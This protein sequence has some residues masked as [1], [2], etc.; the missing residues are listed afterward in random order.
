[1]F[2]GLFQIRVERMKLASLRPAARF[3]AP[4]LVVSAVVIASYNAPVHISGVNAAA[5]TYT[6]PTPT[7]TA[8]A[9][10]SGSTAGMYNV[11]I[12]GTQFCNGTVTVHFGTVLS[13]SVIVNSNTQITSTVP[14]ESAGT[15]DVTVT[16]AGGTSATSSAD[17]FTFVSATAACTAAGLTSDL[18]SPQEVDFKITFTGTATGCPTPQFQYYLQVPGGAWQ[19]AR[20]WSSSATWVW[21]T[22]GVAAIGNF[23]V[24]VW[25]REAG[26]TTVQANHINPYTLTNRVCTAA[27]MTSDKA[28]PQQVDYTITFTATSSSCANPEY[29]FYV[30]L[31]SGAWTIARGYGGP[32]FAWNTTTLASIGSYNINV[33]VRAANSGSA[34]QTNFIMPFTITDRVC[35]GANLTS[36]KTSPQVHGAVIT[37]TATSTGCARPEYKFYLHTPGT[38]GFWVVAQNYGGNTFVWNTAGVASVGAYEVNVWVTAIGSP[39]AVQSNFIMPFTLT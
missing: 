34:V 18:A 19:L 1:M 7:V 4:A 30:Q 16:T 33:W 20:A 12:T 8:I 32:T 25:V 17:Q 29:L 21:D 38:N 6:S 35:S 2:A 5:C 28:S 14:A 11:V 13:T 31:P 26:A 23:N 15:V 9:P 37:F 10:T 39:S 3:L 22:S 24:N 27:G 36:N